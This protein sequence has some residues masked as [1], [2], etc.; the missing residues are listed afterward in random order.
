M[1]KLLLNLCIVAM[2][3][4]TIDNIENENFNEDC[5]PTQEKVDESKSLEIF[6]DLN[7]TFINYVRTTEDNTIYPQYYGGAYINENGVLTIQVTNKSENNIKDLQ[8]RANTTAFNIQEC[9]YSLTELK[10]LKD[11]LSVKFKDKNLKKDLGWVSTGI[12]L[13]DNKVEVRLSNCSNINIEKFKNTI[14]NSPMIQF[15]EMEPITISPSYI[16]DKNIET[17]D[18][19]TNLH[20]GSQYT[21]KGKKSQY[22]PT[23]VTF[24]GSVG[25]RAMKGTKHGFVTA[26]HCL[27]KKDL[28]IKFGLTENDLGTVTAVSLN[29]TSDAAFV[30]VEYNNYYPTNMT[31]I[32]KKALYDKCIANSF[33]EGY[34]VLTE[35]CVSTKAISAKVTSVDNEI[36]ID[37]WSAAGQVTFSPSRVVFA[38]ITGDGP[39]HGD[40]GGIVYTTNGYVAG[41]LIGRNSETGNV[42][43]FSSA[44]LAM[45]DLGVTNAWVK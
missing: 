39:K 40:S 45:K 35:G 24:Q 33:L 7:N 36:D 15:K 28:K 13:K 12:V 8:Q 16:E 11:E 43:I 14:S 42:E 10:T 30:E 25:F 27:P 22:D 21:L 3:I 4:S 18:A 26:A 17:V 2:L 5:I 20:L 29:G 32:N 37:D 23:I 19:Q 1:K 38:T 44:E 9:K 34:T 6:N 41:T 31:H